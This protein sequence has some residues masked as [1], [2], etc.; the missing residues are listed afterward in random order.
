MF[1]ALL[2]S[3]IHGQDAAAPLQGRWV[4]TGAEH[5]G[6]PMNSITGGVMIIAGTGFEIRNASGNVLKGTLRLDLSTRPLTMDFIHADGAEW[7]AIYE[8]A[9]DTL[10]L[11]YVEKGGKD[12]RP[13]AFTTSERTEE[14][15]VVLRREAE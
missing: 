13:R 11:N 10:R 3:V 12:P 7:E 4:V 2:V 5:N 8:I 14:S 6:K 1:I 15:L 9:G